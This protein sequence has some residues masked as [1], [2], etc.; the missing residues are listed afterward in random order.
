MSCWRTSDGW[1]T[2]RSHRKVEILA[3]ELS[4]GVPAT[5]TSVPGH[6]VS[7]PRRA[8]L[9]ILGGC[10]RVLV[11]MVAVGSIRHSVAALSYRVLSETIGSRRPYGSLLVFDRLTWAVHE[12]LRR[13]L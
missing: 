1:R 11:T 10:R 7:W 4:A 13:I 8:C 12:P 5:C 2:H 3:D 9:L 6:L